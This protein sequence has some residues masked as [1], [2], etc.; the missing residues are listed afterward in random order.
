[1]LR[2]PYTEWIGDEDH[3][4]YP[5]TRPCW[6]HLGALLSRSEGAERHTVVDGLDMSGAVPGAVS[7]WFRALTGEW[8]AVVHYAVPYADGRRAVNLVDQLVPGHTV[9]PRKA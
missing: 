7:G 6:V 9:T 8:L 4:R 2:T 5:R 3:G 1:M